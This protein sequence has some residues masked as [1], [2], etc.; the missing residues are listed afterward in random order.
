LQLYILDRN[1][2]IAAQKVPDKYKFKMLI[3][4]GQLICSAG[5]SDVYKKIPQ[6]K[7]LQ[8]WVSQYK[9]WTYKYFLGLYRWSENNI[10]MELKTSIKL[11]TILTQLSHKC[12]SEATSS[13]NPTHGHF[14]YEKNY[15]C[16]VESKSLLPIDK[17]I[18]EYTKYIEYKMEAK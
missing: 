15:I 6:G 13:A 9:I 11:I 4:L 1:P 16:D 10:K 3:E 17:C 8:D 2:I 12:C 14:R 5:I 7:E 18:E